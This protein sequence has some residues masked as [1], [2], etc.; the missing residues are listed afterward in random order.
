MRTGE[1]LL[2]KRQSVL[3]SFDPDHY[4]S[5]RTWATATDGARVPGTRFVLD[6]AGKPA[7]ASG[8]FD[9]WRVQLAA[10][11]ALDNV[12]VKLSG[13]VTEADWER[14]TP[15][16]LAPVVEHVL[17]SFG[18]SRVMLGSDWPVCLLAADYARVQ[19]AVEPAVAALDPD[20]QRQVRGEAAARWYEVNR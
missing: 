13:M 9:D 20:D 3:G 2:R 18:P 6:H 7:I 14:W 12:A 4:E 16:D 17:T 5:L 8:E 11:A 1:R 15:A 10:L 19:A